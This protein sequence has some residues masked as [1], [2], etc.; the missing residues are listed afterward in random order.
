MRHIVVLAVVAGITIGLGAAERGQTPTAGQTPTTFTSAQA[1]AG[2]AAYDA[3]C[4]ACHLRDLRGSN[5]AA[6]LAGANF[7]NQWGDKTIADLHA[8]LMASMPPTSPGSP[9]G[10]AMLDII[11]YLL[12]ANGASAGSQPL[13][14]DDRVDVPRR[15]R[16]AGQAS[17]RRGAAA[18]P[19]PPLPAAAPAP[20]TAAAEASR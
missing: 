13:A 11:A 16:G 10:Q 3:N 15:D 2:R 18:R 9:G 17:R 5:E 20:R 12:Q 7:L 8:Y 4:S 19:A 6:Q 1:E 14:R